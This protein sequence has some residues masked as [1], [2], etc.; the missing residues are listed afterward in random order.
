MKSPAQ[1]TFRQASVSFM[2]SSHT[3]SALQEA[4]L[5][6]VA[7]PQSWEHSPQFAH[8]QLE[9]ENECEYQIRIY[10]TKEL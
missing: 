2:T 6:R 4:N 1:G 9:T 10:E 8:S 3:A 7:A 5:V